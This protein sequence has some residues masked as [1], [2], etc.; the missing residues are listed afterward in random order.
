MDIIYQFWCAFFAQMY[1]E[2]GYCVCVCVSIQ[3]HSN[4]EITKWNEV[5]LVLCVYGTK[6]ETIL[7]DAGQ[8]LACT[9]PLMLQSNLIFFSPQKKSNLQYT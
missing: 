7:K 3:P 5:K 8:T 2:L 1:E 6:G 4:F 9:G